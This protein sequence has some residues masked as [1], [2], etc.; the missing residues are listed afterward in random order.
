LI[1]IKTDR[2]KVFWC[3]IALGLL[4]DLNFIIEF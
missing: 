2:W 1:P 3:R 4:V